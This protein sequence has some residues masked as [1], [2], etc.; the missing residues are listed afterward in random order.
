MCRSIVT[1][2]HHDEHAT[3]E[4]IRAAALQF[5]RKISGYRVPS[6]RNEQAFTKAVEE[7]ARSSHALLDAVTHP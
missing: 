4:E 5:V 6:K 7:I 3:E 2:R 1:L